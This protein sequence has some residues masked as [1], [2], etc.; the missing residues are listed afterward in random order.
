LHLRSE[1]IV[2][3]AGVL[4]GVVSIDGPTISEVTPERSLELGSPVLDLGSRWLLPGFIDGHVHGGGGAQC[5]T[6]DTEEIVAMARFHASH[7]TTAVLAT[8]VAADLDALVVAVGTIASVAGRREEGAAVV[9]GSHLE[10]PFLNRD[11]AGAMDASVFLDPSGDALSRLLEAGRGTVRMVTLA[12]ELP[13]ALTV[14]RELAGLGVVVSIG[15]T[16]AGYREVEAAVA[17]GARS[18]T[19][20]FNAMRPLDHREPGVVGAVLDFDEVSCELICDGVHVDPAALRLAWRAKGTAG[21]RLVTDAIQAA[22]MPDGSY[23][24]GGSSVEVRS[25]RARSAGGDVIAGSTLTMDVALRNAVRFLGA[26]VV[27]AS[28]MASQNPARVLGIERRKGAI[29]AGLDADLVVL[30]DS[31]HICATMVEGGWVSEA[32]V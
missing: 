30:D 29:A 20:L 28:A 16:D 3:P 27:D 13:D 26:T 7:G 5:N 11:R 2:T 10:G 17:A 18:A 23:A 31:L 19:H 32:P 24:L 25:G 21:V 15:H 14:V 22:G 8:T 6:S 9:L 12:P 4:R 1:R